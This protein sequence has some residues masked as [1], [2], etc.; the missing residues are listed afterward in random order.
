MRKDYAEL[1]SYFKRKKPEEIGSCLILPGVT[2]SSGSNYIKGMV[3]I[4]QKNGFRPI[5]LNYRGIND[6]PIKNNRY[7]DLTSVDDIR[8]AVDHIMTEFKD[9][10]LYIVGVSMG[11]NLGMRYLGEM[12]DNT[13][14]KC[15]V[16]VS[17][18]FDLK[19]TVEDLHYNWRKRLY[20]R[21]LTKALIKN[22]KK[23]WDNLD[24]DYLKERGITMEEIEKS[25]TT[26]EFDESF[27]IKF[28]GWKSSEEYSDGMSSKKFIESISKPVLVV[29]SLNDPISL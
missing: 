12:K 10:P 26:K 18:P 16:A 28:H 1:Q 27:T 6:T 4:L 2:G 22:L 5:V 8:A 20:T 17:N 29:N 23:N 11:A 24:K 13:P 25:K 14:V 9:S 7:L 3:K 15:M 21:N 19:A